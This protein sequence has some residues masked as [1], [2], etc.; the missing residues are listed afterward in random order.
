MRILT[1]ALSAAILV[2]VAS[3]QTKPDGPTD[4]KAQKTYKQALQELHDRNPQF[5]L[6]DFKKADKQDGGHCAALAGP[7]IP[8]LGL[9]LQNCPGTLCNTLEL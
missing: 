5:A 4:G 2:N 6:E 8:P 7:V 3:A 1:A 9:V